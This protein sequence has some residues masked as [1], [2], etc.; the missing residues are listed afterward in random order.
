MIKLGAQRKGALDDPARVL[1]QIGN[2]GNEIALLDLA[3][4]II[5]ETVF[6]RVN[7][8]PILPFNRTSKE[9]TKV[10]LGSAYCRGATRTRSDWATASDSTALP[11]RGGVWKAQ[12][13]I[14]IEPGRPGSVR[15]RAG[16]SR[17]THK[18]AR[19]RG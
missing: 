6:V 5:V 18:R 14:P 16:S 7:A 3:V 2:F 17:H 4:D 8:L 11:A 12:P 10:E 9:T 19:A 15:R 13:G 1:G